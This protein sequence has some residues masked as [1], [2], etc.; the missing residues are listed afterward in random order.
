MVYRQY[1]KPFLHRVILLSCL[2]LSGC[3]LI[4]YDETRSKETRSLVAG[5]YRTDIETYLYQQLK[6]KDTTIIQTG[7]PYN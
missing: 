2:G 4:S 7:M 5:C 6:D 1:M 3:A